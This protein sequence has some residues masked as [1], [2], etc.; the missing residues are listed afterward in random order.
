LSLDF[1]DYTLLRSVDS[2]AS[3]V[4]PS[5]AS[6]LMVDKRHALEL[7]GIP[8]QTYRDMYAF[9]VDVTTLR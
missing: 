8:F 1:L 2:D 9:W 5:V 7:E 6:I 4:M 3:Y